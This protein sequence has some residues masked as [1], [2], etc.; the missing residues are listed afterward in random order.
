MEDKGISKDNLYECL[1]T[2]G[3]MGV[4]TVHEEEHIRDRI[5]NL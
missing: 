3:I 5:E 4:I 2:L 1:N